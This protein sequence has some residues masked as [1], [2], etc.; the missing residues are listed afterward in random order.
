MT[1]IACFPPFSWMDWNT[2]KLNDAIQIAR[3][4]ASIKEAIDPRRS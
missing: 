1:T 4:I 2:D 3:C